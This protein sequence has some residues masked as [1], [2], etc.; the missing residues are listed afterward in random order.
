MGI[1]N[2]LGHSLMDNDELHF[3]AAAA[4]SREEQWLVTLSAPLSAFNGDFVNTVSTG[5]S[6]GDLRDGIAQIWGVKDRDSFIETANWLAAEGQRDTY[7]PLWEAIIATDAAAESTPPLLRAAMDAFFPAFYQL[8]ARNQFDY[9]TLAARSGSAGNTAGKTIIES[10]GWLGALRKQFNVT[11]SQI[12]SLLAWDAVRLASLSRW[13]VQLGYIDRAE[14]AGFA[15]A[16]APDV[17]KTYGAWPQVSAA[18]I[19]AGLIWQHSEG[20]EE[21]LLRTNGLLMTDRNSPYRTVAF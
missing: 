11:P 14:F 16:L 4:V 17:R 12:P 1:L 19:A 21:N 10:R 5:K 3:D 13:A 6:D 20:R 2:S 18:Y 7:K 15:G 8:K 9:R